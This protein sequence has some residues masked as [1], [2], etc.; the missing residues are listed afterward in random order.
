MIQLLSQFSRDLNE[1]IQTL[2]EEFRSG[3]LLFG[4]PL[5]IVVAILDI[6]VTTFAIYYILRI[7]ADSRAW[8]LLKG[9]IL[10]FVF[11]QVFGLL[12]LRTISYLMV[13]SISILTFGL[14]VLFQPELRRTLESVGRNSL[15]VFSGVSTDSTQEVAS[16]HNF[17]ESIVLA[18]E[19]MAE[20]YTGALIIIE[21][22]T[23]LG[24]LLNTGSAVVLDSTLTSTT[25]QQIFYKGSPLHDGAVLI[26]QGRIYAARVH[27]PLS[28]NYHMRRD[29][30]TRHRAAVGASEIGD[31]IGIV[32]S[33]E[34]GAVSVTVGGRLYNMED[35]DALRTVLHRLLTPESEVEESKGLRKSLRRLFRKEKKREDFPAGGTN[36]SA[37]ERRQKDGTMRRRL[38]YLR[39]ISLLVA[40][41]SWFYVQVVT[42]PLRTRSYTVPL[43]TLNVETLWENN[44]SYTKTDN[45][46]TVV[47]KARQSTIESIESDMVDAAI[48]FEGITEPMAVVTMDV[49]VEIEGISEFTYEIVS[50]NPHQVSVLIVEVSES[51][52]EPEGSGQDVAPLPV[53]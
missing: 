32:V 20:T 13:S 33:E 34:R 3:F 51:P 37:R 42:N 28:D 9:L 27:V 10:I 12:G 50:R 49:A 29:Y 43:Q 2:S 23:S 19:R 8:Q 21:R 41:L 52:V 46:V 18:C 7:L 11:T 30:G 31:A 48:N 38:I 6:L 1:L 47:V 45:T 26:R 17:V 39:V 53:P 25:L 14:V 22:R 15:R 35:M 24:E 4:S 16:L 36:G 5:D 40:I 44:L